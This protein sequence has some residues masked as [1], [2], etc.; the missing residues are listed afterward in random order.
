MDFLCYSLL[1][2]CHQYDGIRALENGLTHGLDLVNT[3]VAKCGHQMRLS[4]GP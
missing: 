3:G 1:T 4:N 2:I